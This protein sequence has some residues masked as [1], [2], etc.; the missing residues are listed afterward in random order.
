MD[1]NFSFSLIAFRLW[2]RICHN[3]TNNSTQ[4][5]CQRI[6]NYIRLSTCWFRQLVPWAG[7][8]F[9]VSSKETSWKNLLLILIQVCWE[10]ISIFFCL[11]SFQPIQ[12]I[13]VH[14]S[15][16]PTIVPSLCDYCQCRCCLSHFNS[17]LSFLILLSPVCFTMVA[18]SL[19]EAAAAATY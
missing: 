13:F 15:A 12:F 2:I 19:T 16:R 9:I 3:S 18:T 7:N 10:K 6:L 17:F 4:I 5:Q 1:I 14:R 11:F 8:W